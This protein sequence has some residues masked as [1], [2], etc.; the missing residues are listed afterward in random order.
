M[1]G[2]ATLQANMNTEYVGRE[3]MPTSV[4]AWPCLSSG[5]GTIWASW[6]SI[7][8]EHHKDEE[9]DTCILGLCAVLCIYMPNCSRMNWQVRYSIGGW[10]REREASGRGAISIAL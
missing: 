9:R 5:K 8:V 10:R 1:R 3:G 2:P 6:E 7:E 4:N